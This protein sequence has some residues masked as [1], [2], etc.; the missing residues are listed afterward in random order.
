MG[1]NQ[2]AQT[3][4]RSLNN[5]YY[6][7]VETAIG[8][9]DR[10]IDKFYDWRFPFEYTTD[11]GGDRRW[12]SAVQ[13]WI[14]RN[15][16]LVTLEEFFK[17]SGTDG[18]FKEE[19]GGIDQDKTTD[20]NA[21]KTTITFGGVDTTTSESTSTETT[22]APVAGQNEVQKEYLYG[23]TRTYSDGRTWNQIL[24]DALNTEGPVYIY[25]NG[26]SNL[27]LEPSACF[28]DYP[29]PSVQMAVEATSGQV[30]A[31]TIE[32]RGTP[33]NADWLLSLTLQPGEQGPQGPQGATGA[34]GPQGEKGETGAQGP[35]GPTGPQGPAGTNGSDGKDYLIYFGDVGLA[36]VPS[37]TEQITLSEQSFNRAPIPTEYAPVVIHGNASVAG[38]SWIAIVRILTVPG[39]TD[40][41]A[42]VESVVETTGAQGP[43]GDPGEGFDVSKIEVWYSQTQ[44]NS[45]ANLFGGDWAMIQAA[46]ILGA[47]ASRAPGDT[48]GQEQ[49]IL[50]S[51]QMP[52]HGHN[53][54]TRVRWASPP[55]SNALQTSWAPDT[56]NLVI[57]SSDI[58]TSNT[59]DGDPHNNMP[60]YY[61]LYI[62]RRV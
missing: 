2:E 19:Y 9:T 39:N 45:P 42:E 27:L 11:G 46:F 38:R 40:V 34:Q 53:T 23:K 28:C 59:G 47:G 44:E 56:G 29:A 24:A 31:A 17:Q 60:P 4:L 26:F 57:N 51:A 25:I 33:L 6:T 10:I 48:G 32:N 18:T 54:N 13:S 14:D 62:W 43:K 5:K 16:K 3:I 49:V 21:R 55:E 12:R 58:Y 22:E 37:E 61:V 36:F 52:S 30:S 50:T 1:T 35:A 8:L 20:N 15:P 7:S 41:T